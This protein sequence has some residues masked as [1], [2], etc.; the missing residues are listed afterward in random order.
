MSNHILLKMIIFVL[1][2]CAQRWNACV[3]ANLLKIKKNRKSKF[4]NMTVINTVV[5]VFRHR[6]ASKTEKRQEISRYNL[7]RPFSQFML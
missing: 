1:S 4:V 6:F 5:L 7:E 3:A 2:Y